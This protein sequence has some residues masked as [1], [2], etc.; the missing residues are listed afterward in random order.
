M[1]KIDPTLRRFTI[2][3]GHEGRQEFWYFFVVLR[4]FEDF[5]DFKIVWKSPKMSYLS[6]PEQFLVLAFS[7]NFCSIKN[8]PVW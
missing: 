1:S 5:N 3:T 6:F 4:Y 2:I 7:T 8:W